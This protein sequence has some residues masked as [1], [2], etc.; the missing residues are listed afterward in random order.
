MFDMRAPS[1]MPEDAM[2]EDA[3]LEDERGGAR[4]E[5]P[6]AVR[7]SAVGARPVL[8]WTLP[9][10]IALI[11]ANLRPALASVGPV[12]VEIRRQLGLSSA[13]GAL[14]TTIPLVC[15]GLLAPLAPRLARRY[16]I[17]RVL[18]GALA[19][20]GL[21][22]LVRVAFGA[23]CLFIVTVP[24]ASAIAVANVLVPALVKRDFPTRVGVMMGVYT[25]ALSAAAAA[26]AGVT[27]PLDHR[28][29]WGW[30]GALAA[31]A[32][33]AFVALLVWLPQVRGAGAGPA[34]LRAGAG[35][36][37]R[38]RRDRV[39]WQITTFMGLQ[40]LA[41]YAVLTWLPAIY[42]DLGYRAE[43]AG[44]L[45]SISSAVQ[46]PVSLVVP[47]LAARAR[48]QRWFAVAGCLLPAVALVGILVAPVSGAYVWAALLGVGQGT[49]FALALTLVVLRS[50]SSEV[51]ARASAMAQTAG[52]LIAASGPL[53]LGL[54][55]D[56]SGGWS[57][58][59][60][61]LLALLVPQL[62]TALGASRARYLGD[63]P[64]RTV[65]SPE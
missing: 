61:L 34:T 14:L 2:S 21:G 19:V 25:M 3:T 58:A 10:G 5:R 17:Q 32:V 7:P 24:V 57:L 29:G 60:G 27:A 59:I 9:V 51:A 44:L 11:A 1:A 18:F 22:L 53:L 42:Q 52:Y 6:P 15:F 36:A 4:P 50:R 54:V 47:T 30:R 37:P 16:G 39:A 23:A 49:A 55:R 28:L 63:Q 20:I 8:W 33:P 45:L 13:A 64:S 62:L 41:F 40:S 46:A 26:A 31:W 12:L 43:S 38:L 48:D 56:V 35:T 65:S